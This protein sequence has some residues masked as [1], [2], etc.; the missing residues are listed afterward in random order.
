MSITTV[1]VVLI[2]VAILSDKCNEIEIHLQ[3]GVPFT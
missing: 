3:L 1:T 2:L